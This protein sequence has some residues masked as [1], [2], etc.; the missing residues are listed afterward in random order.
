MDEDNKLKKVSNLNSL[1]GQTLKEAIRAIALEKEVPR[2]DAIEIIYNELESKEYKLK[3]IDPPKNILRFFFSFYNT[4]F[5]I[6][7]IYVS[8][9]LYSIIALP[10]VYPFLYIRFG[11]TLLLTL[12]IPGY[13]IM[14]IVTPNNLQ[15]E[16]LLKIS[17]G[18]IISYLLLAIIGYMLA[19][20][21]FMLK[22]GTITAILLSV[23]TI[24]SLIL[25]IKK[26]LRRSI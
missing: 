2:I 17:L 13:L 11:C 19:S 22:E 12:F 15:K 5:W 23:T 7:A 16:T 4:Y 1:K 3:D 9:T 25:S 10:Q 6:M 20:S 24:L 21:S 8:L 26:Y 18:I 14:E